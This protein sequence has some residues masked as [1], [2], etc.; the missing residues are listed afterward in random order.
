MQKI[1]YKMFH[2]NKIIGISSFIF[3]FMLLIYIFIYHLEDTPLAYIAYLWSTYDLTIF[4]IWFI[5]A[6]K[7][8]HSFIKANSN[9]YKLYHLNSK[10]I[11]QIIL[12]LSS[13]INLI[14]GLFKLI[15]GIYY[16]SFWFITVSIYYLL[17]CF[18]KHFLVISI[19]KDSSQEDKYK[20]L[21]ITGIIFLLLNLILFG[22]ILLIICQNQIFNYPGYLIYIVALYDFYLI[23]NAFINVFKYHN[24]DSP[25]LLASKCINLSVA[26]ISMISLE[27]AMIYQFGNNDNA[28]KIITISIT[29]FVVSI[30]N[31]LMALY[32]IIKSHKRIYK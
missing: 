20:S 15:T 23:I 16:R 13:S 3:G 14:Y 29:G 28:F 2:P 6:C 9:I 30:I 31:T 8:S 5:K 11:L 10:K 27:V 25:I 24:H 4:I 12:Y 32:M 18:I 17:L 26:M 1:L 19:Q 22:M 21:K 7:F